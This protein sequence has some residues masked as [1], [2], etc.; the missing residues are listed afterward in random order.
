MMWARVG[1]RGAGGVALGVGEADAADLGE[2]LGALHAL[3]GDG[4]ALG[5]GE[6]DDGADQLGG[7]GV[8]EV[9]DEGLVELDAVVRQPRQVGERAVAGAEVVER[10][11]DAAVDQRVELADGLRV[12]AHQHGLG[13][14]ELEPPGREAGGRR[15]PRRR[16]R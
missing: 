4:D 16:R 5:A 13:D 15:A 10:D 1:D 7:R 14:L 3:G 9:L 6:R 11:A 8:A 12:V 2:L